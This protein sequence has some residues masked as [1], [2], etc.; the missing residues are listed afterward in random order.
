MKRSFLFLLGSAR[1]DGN[2]ELL[3]RH[4]ARSLPKSAE[5]TWLHLM[6]HS[7]PL[8]EDIRHHETRKYAIATETERTLLDATL[9]AT[10]IVIASPVY[11]YSV[12]AATKLYLDHWSAWM[13]LPDV[14][15]KKHMVGKTLWVISAL[16]DEDWSGAQPLIDTIRLSAEYMQMNWGGV[17]LGYGNRPGDVLDHSESLVRAEKFFDLSP[18]AND[19]KA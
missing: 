17:L 13:R 6:E 18:A 5:Q 4:A 15:F 9:S 12:S 1:R 16:S 14:E 2:T 10:D 8:F 11:W 3:A 19:T 7:L